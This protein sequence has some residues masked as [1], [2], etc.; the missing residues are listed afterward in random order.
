MK[1]KILYTKSMD[2]IQNKL[3]GY[4]HVIDTTTDKTYSVMDNGTLAELSINTQNIS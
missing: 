1:I 4:T 2:G 3:T